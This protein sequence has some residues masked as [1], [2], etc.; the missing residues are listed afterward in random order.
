MVEI[1]WD[2]SRS[3]H[4]LRTSVI[5]PASRVDLFAFFGDAFQLEKITPPWLN[6]RVLTSAPIDIQPGTLIDYRL[7]LR[8]IPIRWRTEISTWDPPHSFTDRQLKG[9]YYLWEHLHTFEDVDGGTRCNDEVHYQVPG[10]RIV[11][12]LLVKH[13][14]KKIFQYRQQAMIEI[15]GQPLDEPNVKTQSVFNK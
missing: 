1:S 12:S 2:K 5:L 8:G 14:L 11:N 9:P 7:R 3:A 4:V 10:G 15:F 6:F 13:D